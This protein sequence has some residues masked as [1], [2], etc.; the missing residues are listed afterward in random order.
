MKRS[1]LLF[2]TLVAMLCIDGCKSRQSVAEGP[3]ADAS[4]A[5]L[6]DLS[7]SLD[8]I[9]ADFNAHK[10]EARFLALLSPA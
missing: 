3:A 10:G 6:T 9:R 7:T 4:T 5:S 2:A 8:A 1:A